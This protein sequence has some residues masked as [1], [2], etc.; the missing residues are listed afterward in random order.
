MEKK[1]YYVAV[2]AREISQIRD[3]GLNQFE[4]QATEDEI[5]RLREVFDEAYS[6]DWLS[7]WRSH[8][9]Y[10]QYHHDKE[11]DMYDDDMKQVFQM[12]YEFGTPETKQQI[13]SIGVLKA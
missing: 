9:P 3:Y 13:E 10:V 4:I 6:A 7:F 5:F 11:N 2:G 8:V 1:T 12:I